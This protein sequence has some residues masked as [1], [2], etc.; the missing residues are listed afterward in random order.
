MTTKI[1][2][3]LRSR[4]VWIGIALFIINGLS[5]VHNMIPASLLPFVDA[6]GLLLTAYFHVNPSQNYANSYNG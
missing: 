5:A 6:V 3:A 4:T 1:G 2:M